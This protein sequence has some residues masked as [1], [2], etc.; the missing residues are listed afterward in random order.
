[1]SWLLSNKNA[2]GSLRETSAETHRRIRTACRS[3]FRIDSSPNVIGTQQNGSD[4]SLI[5]I[6]APDPVQAPAVTLPIKVT[7]EERATHSRFRAALLFE[8]QRIDRERTTKRQLLGRQLAR[9]RT[10][11]F[12]KEQAHERLEKSESDRD[13]FV[14]NVPKPRQRFLNAPVART[15]P[16]V[17]WALWGADTMIIARAWGLFG[18]V[19]VPFVRA[20]GGMAALTMLLRAGLVSFGLIFG[21]RFA[22]SR[23]RDTVDQLR[24]TRPKVGH[25]CDASVA[26]AVIVAAIALA[27]ATAEMQAALLQIVSG[28]S[29]V[30]VPTALL[31]AIVA[32]LITVSLACGYFLNEPELKE[33]RV[34]EQ[35]IKEGFTALDAAVSAE[36]DQRG[37]VRSTIEELRGLDRQ[38]KLLIEEQKAHADEEVFTF[39]AANGPVYGFEFDNEPDQKDGEKDG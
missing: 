9:L 25:A 3:L 39:K 11:R 35:R 17:P 28:G 29:S 18:P 32:F 30:N 37:D 36:D 12:R 13:T 24:A 5:S 19:A 7:A 14:K 31:F 20:S 27:V 1:M 21:V 10:L 26:G 22:G 2:D 8:R 6:K 4:A 23:L 38:E 33:A 16:L 15:M 34:H